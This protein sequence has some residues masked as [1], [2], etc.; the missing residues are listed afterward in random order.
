MAKNLYIVKIKDICTLW[1]FYTL[2]KLKAF[3]SL[4]MFL[5]FVESYHWLDN[6]SESSFSSK[7]GGSVT[8]VIES[9]NNQLRSAT[10]VEDGNLSDSNSSGSSSVCQ[11]SSASSVSSSSSIASDTV[12]TQISTLS[13]QGSLFSSNF[14]RI[15]MD[16]CTNG[17]RVSTNIH[18]FNYFV[19]S[20]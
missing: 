9:N 16:S 15:Q 2:W 17:L 14:T 5:I 13:F 20:K 4:N 8:E 11:S 18:I 7:S 3:V 6:F 10:S 1:K 12:S 19:Y